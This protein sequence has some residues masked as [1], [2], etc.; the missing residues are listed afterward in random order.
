M[1]SDE[2]IADAGQQ[3]DEVVS[4][5]TG[6]WRPLTPCIHFVGGEKGG[7]GKS[8]VS[9]LL[10]QYFIDRRIAF[11]AYD[12]DRSH[13]AL[14]RYYTDYT[15]PLDAG[16]FENLDQLFEV[17]QDEKKQVLV[18]LAAQTEQDLNHWLDAGDVPG[19]AAAA[20]V[21]I[22]FWQVID[23]GHDSQQ[24]LS[25]FLDRF[26]HRPLRCVVIKNYGRGD[27]FLPMHWSGLPV[28]L[29]MQHIPVLELEAL[30]AGTMRKID[31]CGASFW[32]A[33]N[34]AGQVDGRGLNRLERGRVQHWLERFYN[35][36]D[37]L[38]AP[39]THPESNGNI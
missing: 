39:A 17:A 35:Q 1:P 14:L 3:H 24:L 16:D 18:D 8:L 9:R 2:T 13:G 4:G 20:G 30:H 29:S 36:L 19:I 6:E 27:N 11:S 21:E 38:L 28:R 7:V 5:Q 34:P 37:P 31:A 22:C 33:V 26:E 23:D 15:L 10:A 32:A 25:G 12:S